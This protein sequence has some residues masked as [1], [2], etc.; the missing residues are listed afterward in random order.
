MSDPTIE[1]SGDRPRSGL[2]TQLRRGLSLLL[3]RLWPRA[4]IMLGFLVMTYV[5]QTIL[6]L[7]TVLQACWLGATGDPNP[8]IARFGAQMA[9][10]LEAV[11]RFQSC[12]TEERPFPWAEWPS[13]PT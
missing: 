11:A 13:Q 10:W 4:A 1:P 12:A 8:R 9:L 7:I 2:L 6:A 3:S 5:A